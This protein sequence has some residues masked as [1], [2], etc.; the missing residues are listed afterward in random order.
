MNRIAHFTLAVFFALFFVFNASANEEVCDACGQLVQ[1][2]GQ[3]A[4][5]KAPPDT[6]I[7]GAPP[8]AEAAF[9]EEIF[10]TNFTVAVSG[11]PAGKYTVVIGEVENYFSKPGDRVFDVT[12]GDTA[13]A[14]NF[15]IVAAAGGA[16]R[17]CFVTGKAEHQ[18]D[19]VDGPLK[20]HFVARKNDAKFNTL[21]IKN[22]SGAALVSLKASD[23]ADAFTAA[24]NK[25]PVV[26][27]PEIWKDPSQP[28][29][30]RV[31]DLIRRMSLAE[32]V[33]QIHNTAPAI[34][35]LGVPAYD[36][37]SEAL[38]GVA[39]AGYATVFPQAIGMAAT[40]DPALIHSEAD[41]ISTE[42]RAKFNDYASKHGGNSI[43]FHGLTFWSPNI[44]IFRD[45][46]WGRGQETYGED[47]FLTAQLAVQFIHGLQG[48]DPRY[49]KAMA[50]AK[51]YDVHSGPEP[52][53]HRFNADPSERDLY[54]TYL[55]QFEAAVRAGRV[56][57]VMG[58]YNAVYGVP[59]CASPFLLTDIL[60]QQWGFNG[61]IVSDCGAIGNIWK[62][63]HYVATPEAAAAVAVKAGCDICC[64]S[65]YNALV[66]A[67]QQGLIT[68]Q[69][70]DA[71]L[72]YT[73]K[74]RFRLGLF[75]PP[76]MVPWSKIGIDQ[77]DTPAHEALALKVAEESVVL[78]KNNG[79][80]PLNR[81]NVK[82]IAVIGPNADSV[83]ALV[84]NYNGTPARP[85]TILDGI[86]Q[87]AGN[88][89]T[90]TYAPGC[91]VALRKDG[92]N[93]PSPQMAADALAAADS[94]DV[95]IF[96]GGI[97]AQ[98]EREESRGPDAF[99]GFSGG[100]RTRIE[101]PEVQE[102]LLQS[103]YAV[104]KPVVFVN[105]SGSAMAVPWAAAHLP[106]ILQA[107][108]PGEQGGRAV[109]EVLFG[110][111]N[112]AG[113]LP[114]TFYRSTA[115]L[116]PFEDY[117][118]SNRT[119]RYFGGQP[120]FAFG[121]GLSYTKFDYRAV[122]LDRSRHTAGDTVKVSFALKNTGPR[123]GDEVTQV[124]F[125]HVDS[126]VPQ[127]KLALCGFARIHIARGQTANVTID[128]PAERFRYWDTATKEY[129]VE[130]GDYQLL[131]GA[132][133]DDIRLR[134][135]LKIAAAQ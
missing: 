94:A 125:R 90:V 113:R 112:P 81:A 18:D 2:T 61:Y 48:D 31:N 70:I 43:R 114:I 131:I 22:A 101:L 47:P 52:E 13:L 130:P 59:C 37:W 135:P 8:G 45:P 105:C 88:D 91:P 77:N 98:Y 76:A 30:A 65:D 67:V 115:D 87:I 14:T 120:L 72:A 39:N 127:P 71:A 21:E 117:A 79:L 123:D 129:A 46:R 7:A 106:A 102:N 24:A 17:V 124:Y 38:H 15:D 36:Y 63:H 83:A 1:V 49:I 11:L 111:V 95:V 50:C 110:D 58:A 78:L 56:C 93:A 86:K 44:N 41:V 104:G 96:V 12:C 3:F 99:V 27:G 73:L 133:S 19:A 108:Y 103:L 89:F 92:A 80:L 4:H 10:G 74:A 107:W 55:P 126:A 51:H 64:G 100:D 9:R 132:A 5:Y 122:R 20:L 32:K 23:L 53:R 68:E 116:P 29:D 42:G 85:V 35:R 6:A 57:G 62:D 134:V 60:R 69:Q 82:R 33:Q 16:G 128:I 84:G 66:K 28:L 26:T 121:H 34:P 75:D 54:E 109:G 25:I 97:T 119:Y 40:W 118:M